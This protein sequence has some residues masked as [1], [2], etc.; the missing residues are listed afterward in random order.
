MKV[1]SKTSVNTQTAP[2]PG[3]SE[4]ALKLFEAHRQQ[5]LRRTDLWFGGLMVFQWAAAIAAA[6]WISPRT[7]SGEFSR[8]HPHLYAS[9]FLGGVITI[10]PVLL[11]C[12]RPGQPLTRHSLAA[13]QMLMGALLIHLT[14]GRIETHFH[15]FGSLAFLAFYR[16][17]RVLITASLVVVVD[18]LLRG[19]YWPQSVYGILAPGIWRSFEHTGWVFFEDLFLIR[20]CRESVQ[21]M[22]DI[23]TQKAELKAINLQIEGRVRQRTADL[24]ASEGKFRS[25]I[26][27]AGSIIVGLR[28]DHTIFEWNREAERVF[29][30][31]RSECLGRDYFEL[32]VPKSRHDV[33]ATNVRQVLSGAEIHN[34]EAEAVNRSGTTLTLLWNVTRLV[35][36]DGQ[37][38]G[39][40]AIGQDVSSR[41]QA[42]QALR[43][44]EALYSSLVEN[45]PQNIFRKDL[46]GCFTFVN[47]R[48]CQSLNLSPE[49]IL[50]KTDFDLFPPDLARKY[51]EDDCRV[52][53]KEQPFEI[54]E[55][56]PAPF[57]RAYVQVVKI[58][59]YDARGECIGVQ[60][61]FWDI[62]ERK[63][64]EAELI[65]REARFRAMSEA[66]PLGIFLTDV[67]GRCIYTNRV[68][69]Q[70]TGLTQEEMLGEGWLKGIHPDDRDEVIARLEEAVR[71]K[72]SYSHTHRF[73]RKNG[74]VVWVS[75]KAA[76]IS[77]GGQVTGYVGTFED[78]SQRKRAEEELLRY[79]RDLE[80]AKKAQERHAAQL[81]KL[82]EELAREKSKAEEA[83]QAKSAF[84]ASMSHEIRTPLN[85]VIGMTGLLLDTPLTPVQKDYAETLRN[86]ADA[87]LNL[88]N[89][90]LDFSKIEA[91]RMTIE[92]IGFDLLSVCEE[93]TEILAA[94][95]AEKSLDLVLRFTPGT[96]QRLVGDAGRI[97]QIL[98]NLAGNAVKFTR[99]G[100]VLIEVENQGIEEQQAMLKVS[101]KDTGIGIPEDKQP[102]LFNKFSQADTS[103]TRRFGGTGLGLAICKQLVELMGG[104]IGLSSAP[105]TGSHFWFTLRL[106]IDTTAPAPA[107]VSGTLSGARILVVDDN[108]VNLRVI[109]ENLTAW[110]SRWAE[111]TAGSDTLAILRRASDQ[112]DP[113]QVAILDHNM[114]EMD[115]LTLARNVLS[116]PSIAPLNLV[117]L[118]SSGQKG[119]A[120][121]CKEAGFTAYLVKPVR[122]SLLYEVLI[123]ALAMQKRGKSGPLITRYSL[124]E[125]RAA[126]KP[127][128]RETPANFACRILLAED[129]PVNQRV[130]RLVLEKRGCRVDVAGNGREALEMASKLPYDLI[131]M[132]C[133]MPEMDGYSATA[134][135]RD[136]EAQKAGQCKVEGSGGPERYPARIPIVALTAHALR[137]E[138]EKCLAVG[139]DDFVTKPFKP[140][141]LDAVLERWI[142][143]SQ[144]EIGKPEPKVEESPSTEDLF[145]IDPSVLDEL[146]AAGGA[147][148]VREI[149]A[150]YVVDARDQMR[151]LRQAAEKGDASS[152]QQ[153][154]H[155]LKGGSGNVGAAGIA[156]KCLEIEEQ[157][158][159]GACSFKPELDQLERELAAVIQVLDTKAQRGQDRP[160]SR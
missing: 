85:G 154:A 122:S 18:H 137:E 95:A 136:L 29:G 4:M 79:A 109:T 134:A 76:P 36:A 66:S 24:E 15:V 143:P 17:W 98:L 148:L 28:A 62:T 51:Q 128:G 53:A 146:G 21:E 5:I 69:Q 7:W 147:E 94:N 81:A 126:G 132:D 100:H 140:E 111:A 119:E 112:G 115:G 129:N 105:G 123:Q 160:A 107:M 1:T 138:R 12:F 92:P 130:A 131:L 11:A 63:R 80:A 54:V 32:V 14:G 149:V 40:I 34:Y 103:T 52:R 89:D 56:H 71:G 157:A 25:L 104:S 159:T 39:I 125:A 30:Y 6:L 20:A 75:V 96:P 139:M 102:V 84:L 23:A 78:I 106:P 114:P 50:G 8:I 46:D 73:L 44:S 10:F 158:R 9:L 41:K 118:T 70:I 61:M 42:E 133:Q 55:E 124:A 72:V 99:S 2:L 49:Q 33:A 156:Q 117:M 87:L 13:A 65:E 57:G 31:S 145:T 35:G 82:V 151:L 108:P 86:S 150:L 135:I 142:K 97:R 113:F 101:V 67:A 90:I 110:G 3:T 64:T 141:A 45:I 127:P 155:R 38:F 16:D 153:A 88:I 152:V 60:G 74:L 37:V 91:G 26:E 68:A 121:R 120:R 93:V 83:T 116:D 59:L 43:D 19:I 144:S 22:R 47:R 77:Q 48:F 27:T 58:P